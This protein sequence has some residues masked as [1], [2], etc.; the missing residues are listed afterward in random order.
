MIF[1]LDHIH[2][3][4]HMLRCIELAELGRGE[5]APNPMVGAV[6]V[7]Q[8]RIIGEGWHQK[9]GNA[10]AEVN[11]LESVVEE[12]QAFIPDST[13][14]VSLEPC[15]HFGK[16]P[17]CVNLIVAK[18]IKKVVIASL[19]PNPLVAG[20][21]IQILK[22]NDIE[23]IEGI[24]DEVQRNL[25]RRFYTSHLLKRPYVVLKWAQ[26]KDGFIGIE[27]QRVKISDKK[28]DVLAHQW[29][30]EEQAILVGTRTALI[31][32][33]QL[34]ARLFSETKHPMRIVLDRNLAI[35]YKAHLYDDKQPTFIF[36]A[37]ENKEISSRTRLVKLLDFSPNKIVEAIHSLGI[38]SVLIEGGAAVLNQFILANIWDEAKVIQAEL[39]IG[40]GIPAPIL[41]NHFILQE[42]R[43]IAADTLFFYR[44]AS[45]KIQANNK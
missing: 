26:S 14:Y 34:N 6:L 10:H 31:D 45:Q 15:A 32:D 38:Q 1:Y 30:A 43:R 24:C 40:L 21:G 4:N 16:T 41:N 27:N 42:E 37:I 19:D 9:Y 11:C 7:Y 5:V 29:R 36:N 3:E 8:N 20:K 22:D 13:L 44:N 25:N 33:P 17:P 18:K 28:T 23:V 39:T 2:H 35:P 12:N